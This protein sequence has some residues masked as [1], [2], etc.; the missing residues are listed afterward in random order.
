MAW[1]SLNGHTN[2]QYNRYCIANNTTLIHELLLHDIKVSIWRAINVTWINKPTF[3]FWHNKFTNIFCTNLENASVQAR[4]NS[5]SHH[6]G[7]TTYTAALC[8]I[9]GDWTIHYPLWP[10]HLPN[11]TICYYFLWRTTKNSAHKNNQNTLEKNQETI[12][13]K[14]LATAR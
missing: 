9:S 5:F 8:S 12:R 2:T 3:F 11:L 1:F 14:V 10:A 4:E 6:D 7:A 13:S